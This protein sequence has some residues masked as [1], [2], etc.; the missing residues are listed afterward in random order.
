MRVLV[1]TEI[2]L[3]REGVAD[4]LCRLED[5]EVA[6]TA[7]DAATAVVAARQG[8]VDVVLLD[9]TLPDTTRAARSLLAARPHV[10]VVALAAPDEEPA[11]IACAEAGIVGYVSREATLDDLAE[12]LRCTMRGE[13]PCSTRVA[14]GLLHH[15]AHQARAR[16]H[17]TLSVQLTPREREV[18]RLVESGLSNKQIA[19]ALDLQLSTVK[20]HVHNILGKY[21]AS[22][23][24]DLTRVA[25][26][27]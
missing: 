15:I 23:R 26:L 8:E 1:V 16:G 12:A 14:A 20:N 25:V 22:G 4:A 18:L 17:A 9:M 7:D 6:L 27:D 19:H 24:F 5:V 2:R 3:Y 13:A 10:K 11:V 21:G